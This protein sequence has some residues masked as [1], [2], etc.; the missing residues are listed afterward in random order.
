MSVATGHDLFPQRALEALP[1]GGVAPTPATEAFLEGHFQTWDVTYL[2]S[3]EQ[4]QR[5]N[6][7]DASLARAETRLLRAAWLRAVEN[8]P[9][10]Y[11]RERVA[12]FAALLGLSGEPQSTPVGFYFGY[13]GLDN[14]DNFGYGLAFPGR[15]ATATSV[16]E[17]FIGN[18]ARLPLDRPWVYLLLLAAGLAVI[19]RT[20][21]R[22]RALVASIAFGTVLNQVLL[23]FTVMSAATRYEYRIT[24]VSLVVAVYAIAAARERAWV[25][26]RP[27]PL[28][29]A[30]LRRTTR[31]DERS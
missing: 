20:R 18:R 21:S 6:V 29:L 12:L 17:L 8:A 14:P 15:Y 24:E 16:L 1:P 28:S 11:L 22:T 30:S 5:Q 4:L 9:D 7:T 3:V 2:R 13:Q 26:K 10:A 23:F 25:P 19:D 27:A 31:L